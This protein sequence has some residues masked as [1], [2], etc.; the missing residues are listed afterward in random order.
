MRR[1]PVTKVFD[2]LV[3]FGIMG[4]VVLFWGGMALAEQ[5]GMPDDP[6]V[7]S[8]G[9]HDDEM[10]DDEE[11]AIKITAPL[12]KAEVFMAFRRAKTEYRELDYKKDFVDEIMEAAKHSPF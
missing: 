7:G 9:F 11:E 2:W 10:T 3:G 4:L 1:C 6:T 12:P 5:R 8:S